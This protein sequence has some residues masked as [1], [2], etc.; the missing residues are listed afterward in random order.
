MECLIRLM[1]YVVSKSQEVETSKFGPKNI[2]V[3]DVI[4]GPSFFCIFFG[5]DCRRP[6]LP[7]CVDVEC[8]STLDPIL[9]IAYYFL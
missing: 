1:T 9:D 2:K 4:S 7:Q 6:S 3:R 5:S 8:E